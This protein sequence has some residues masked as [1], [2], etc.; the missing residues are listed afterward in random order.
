MCNAKSDEQ[1]VMMDAS[2]PLDVLEVS[3]NSATSD[4]GVQACV[5]PMCTHHSY[6]DLLQA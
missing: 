5:T 3:L 1:K 6:S 2:K 4:V